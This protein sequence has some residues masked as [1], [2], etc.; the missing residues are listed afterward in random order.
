ML[1]AFYA[2]MIA[3]LAA[4]Y[5]SIREPMYGIYVLFLA[6]AILACGFIDGSI[7]RWVWPAD[8]EITRRIGL[9]SGIVVGLSF[10]AFVIRSTE[11]DKYWHQLRYVFKFIL[12]VTFVL[13]I[14]SLLTHNF[15]FAFSLTQIFASLILPIT[16]AVIVVAVIKRVP[17][18]IYLQRNL[19]CIF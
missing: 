5:V 13:G 15:T 4:V 14:W 6:S 2:A 11:L 8:P 10:L 3:L 7:A 19:R 9:I 1:V 16:T 17:T 12:G 18:S